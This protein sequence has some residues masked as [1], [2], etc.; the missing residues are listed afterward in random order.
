M[1]HVEIRRSFQRAWAFN[2]DDRA[3]HDGVLEPWLRGALVRMGDRDWLPRESSL[4]ILEG[5]RIEPPDLAHGQGWNRAERT[6]RDVTRELLER[7]R[8]GVAGVALV[9]SDGAA[10]AVGA[11]LL[12]ELGAQVLDWRAL[13]AR[14]IGGRRPDAGDS[15]TALLIA[16]P[17]APSGEWLFDAGLAKGALGARAVVAWLGEGTAPPQLG[18]LDPLVLDPASPQARATLEE[19]LRQ[20][21]SAGR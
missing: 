12:K 11:G 9:A 16:G 5:P 3:L 1:F 4:R 19:R 20:A 18:E 14:L 15:P 8:K 13:R 6:A 17:P 21:A 7:E 10:H 2:L